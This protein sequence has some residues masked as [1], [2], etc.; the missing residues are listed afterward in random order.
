MTLF[1][2]C[3]LIAY[4]GTDF[5]TEFRFPTDIS[6]NEFIGQ[7]RDATGEL[8][9]DLTFITSGT[10]LIVKIPKEI[11]INCPAGNYSYD[12]LMI[13]DMTSPCIEG[14]FSIRNTRTH[15]T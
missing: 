8:I 12:I 10:S 4:K 11:T 15:T 6:A 14:T 13:S 3:D 1:G 2:K 9:A 7:V 5:M